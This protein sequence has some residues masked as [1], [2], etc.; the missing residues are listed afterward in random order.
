MTTSEEFIDALNEP[1]QDNDDSAPMVPEKDIVDQLLDRLNEILIYAQCGRL[2]GV[3]TETESALS[4]ITAF[5]GEQQLGE[6]GGDTLALDFEGKN[7][8]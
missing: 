3:I 4:E 1:I 7:N 2:A 6:G 5:K 8:V